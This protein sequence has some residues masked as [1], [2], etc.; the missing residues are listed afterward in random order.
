MNSEKTINPTPLN[1]INVLD[2]SYVRLVDFMGNDL[3]I[4]NAA[5]VS[6]DKESPEFD[7]RDN[8]LISYLIHTGHMSPS[9]PTA[10]PSLAA[11]IHFLQQRMEEDDQHETQ[12]YSHTF[13]KIF[14]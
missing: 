2:K 1:L 12:Q 14:P 6:Y 7:E 13:E 11:M 4:V 10:T 3:S 9:Q 5:R 8:K